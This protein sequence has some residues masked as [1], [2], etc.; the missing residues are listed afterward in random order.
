MRPAAALA[1]CAILAACATGGGPAPG[2]VLPG[3]LTEATISRAVEATGD[4]ALVEPAFHP[5]EPGDDRWWLAIAHAELRPPEAAQHFD[6][7]L[8]TRLTQKRRPALERL[9]GRLLADAEAFTRE[10]ARRHGHEPRPIARNPRLLPCQRVT[11]ALRD[12]PSWPAG[13]AVAGTL[14]GEA[15]AAA[16]PDRATQARWIGA[17][18]GASRVVCR[19][20]SERDVEAGE[21]GAALLYPMIAATP[22]YQADLEGARAEIAAARAEA[23]SN[24]SCAAERRAL[25]PMP[26]EDR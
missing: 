13:G 24:P 23:L 5:P 8:G 4:T 16:A 11:P 18:L 15:V 6:C 9:M 19:M 2:T 21:R 22:D 26:G 3:Y 25:G 14:Y 20:N 1:A 7:A 10:A 17:A 12:S